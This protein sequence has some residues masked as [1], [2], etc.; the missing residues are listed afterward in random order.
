[1]GLSDVQ[2]LLAAD[3]R[4]HRVHKSYLVNMEHV[5]NITPLPDGRALHFDGLAG[6]TVPVPTDDVKS[7]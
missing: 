6:V 7:W 1:M 5:T 2:A 3:V 4:F